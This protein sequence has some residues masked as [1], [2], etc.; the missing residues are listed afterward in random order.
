LK[1][2]PFIGDRGLL[3]AV[4]FVSTPTES[5]E[6]HFHDAYIV[7][8]G[9]SPAEAILVGGPLPPPD[10]VHFWREDKSGVLWITP[11]RNKWPD[12]PID[13]DE[14]VS[15]KLLERLVSYRDIINDALTM[16]SAFLLDRG[17][18]E[19]IK[20]QTIQNLAKMAE[21]ASNSADARKSAATMFSASSDA[22]KRLTD[23]NQKLVQ[24]I[25][26]NK[27]AADALRILDGVKIG[28]G[29]ANA[30][31]PAIQFLGNYAPNISMSDLDQFKAKEYLAQI[32]RQSTDNIQSLTKLRANVSVNV[33]VQLGP[34]RQSFPEIHDLIPY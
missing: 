28:F 29:F 16:R 4:I 23:I 27:R 8:T 32:L 13:F 1:V 21:S 17:T 2:Y 19:M 31:V 7:A 12:K 9:N 6:P 14:A 20:L 11:G 3:V 15:Q 10:G 24:E 34:F 22:L 26:K 18:R 5:S 30:A 33:D 25:D